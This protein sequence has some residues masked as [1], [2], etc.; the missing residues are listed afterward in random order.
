MA[1]R[2]SLD[3]F[4]RML[5]VGVQYPKKAIK[6]LATRK[7]F[8]VPSD[9]W[10]KCLVGKARYGILKKEKKKIEVN[11]D[12]FNVDIESFDELSTYITVT[13]KDSGAEAVTSINFTDNV[14]PVVEDLMI[15]LTPTA[16]VVETVLI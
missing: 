8:Q 15:R 6:E 14:E 2:V 16:K 13:R 10:E 1:K 9:F 5:D 7:G 3:E 4:T 12:D 11:K